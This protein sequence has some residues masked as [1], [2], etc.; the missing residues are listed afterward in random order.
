LNDKNIILAAAALA[1]VAP[2]AWTKFHAAL[3]DY[4]DQRC[5]EM[6]AAPVDMVQIAQ[7]R[8]Q[9]LQ[10]LYRTL[11]NCSRKSENMAAKR[12]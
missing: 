4:A 5:V 7:G 6:V 1:R 10:T 9:A 8:A 3:Y 12:P 2:E 11:E